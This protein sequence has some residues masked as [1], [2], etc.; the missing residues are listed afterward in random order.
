MNMTLNSLNVD[1]SRTTL[2]FL[3]YSNSSPLWTIVN[4][5]PDNYILSIQLI[6]KTLKKNQNHWNYEIQNMSSSLLKQLDKYD[7]TD[8]DNGDEDD[9][10]TPL[11][12]FP[13]TQS[14]SFHPISPIDTQIYQKKIYVK[15]RQ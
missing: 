12:H 6:I 3:D 9:D 14:N 7:N 2:R 5:N 11:L 4:K 8:D 13:S 10:V 1:L 15:S